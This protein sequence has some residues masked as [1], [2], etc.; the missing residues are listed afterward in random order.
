MVKIVASVE[1]NPVGELAMCLLHSVTNTHILH[2]QSHSYAEHMALAAYYEGVGDI[3]DS[4][5]EAY[6]GK[7]GQLVQYSYSYNAPADPIRELEHISQEVKEYRQANG[8]PQ[9]SELQ[10][11]L[12]EIAGL[13]DSTLYKL[14][15]LK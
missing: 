11:I 6:Q 14:R 5:V 9:D 13:I 2:L 15:F 4:F 7:Y 10:N 1:S 8:F 12:D 3:L